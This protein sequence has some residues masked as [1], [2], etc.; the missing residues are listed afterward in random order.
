M[1]E[2]DAQE[3]PKPANKLAKNSDRATAG[4]EE[5]RESEREKGTE[6]EPG[7]RSEGRAKAGRGRR[8]WKCKMRRTSEPCSTCSTMGMGMAWHG[9]PSFLGFTR[10][11]CL[12]PTPRRPA[13]V[14]SSSPESRPRGQLS[15]RP[16]SCPPCGPS[17]TVSFPSSLNISFSLSCPV[18]KKQPVIMFPACFLLC[19]APGR[20]L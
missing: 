12:G 15:R 2:Q 10:S 3:N 13:P 9:T 5:E 16:S 20:I 17:S 14:W 8:A 18:Q 11:A 7:T 1:G 6:D 19:D 4:K